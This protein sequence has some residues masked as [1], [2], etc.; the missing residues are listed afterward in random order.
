MSFIG[1]L[2]REFGY[3]SALLKTQKILADLTPDNTGLMADDWEATCAKHSSKT[4]IIFE[5]TRWTYGE[6][7]GRANRYAHWALAQGLKA[8][9][10]VA[11]YMGNRP[12]YLAAWYGLI[13][14]G[15]VVALINNNL[16]GGPL[17]HCVNIAKSKAVI[18]D[19]EQVAGW[20]T[21]AASIPDVSVWVLGGAA[22]VGSD[23]SEALDGQPVSRPA[24][25]HR[26]MLRGK[27][28]CLYVYTSGTT[29]NPKAATLTQIRTQGMSRAF[30]VG[31]RVNE[32]DVVY[33]P[34]P[35]YHG[36][37]GICGVG[38]AFNTGATLVI[39]RKF[40][41]SQFWD[42]VVDNG[43]T[44]FAYIGEL[45]RYLVAQPVHP[46]ERAHRLK[47]CFGN[48]LRPDVWAKA[49]ERF[50]IPR[51]VEFY[52]STEGNVSFI[53]FDGKRGA[54]GRI[55]PYM[56]KKFNVEIVKFDIEEE[57]PVRGPDGFCIKADFGEPGEAIG[58]I[59]VDDSRGRFEGYANDTAA[60]EKKI[61]RDVFEKGDVW[62]RT[63][64]LIKT[65]EEG[66][67]YFVDRIGD[68][69][70]WKSEN[71]STNEVG[72]VLA[73]FEGIQL[74]NVYGVEVPHNDGRA[75]M[76]AIVVPG[77]A[78]SIDFARL[79]AHLKAQLPAYAIPL[80]LRIQPEAEVTG[81]FKYRK[82]DAVKQGYDPA[83]CGEPV[84]WLDPAAG[85]YV[86]V[87]AAAMSRMNEGSVKF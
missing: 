55:A 87:D 80:F 83:A 71:V 13:K 2:T 78:G 64:D 5:G 3:V 36:T 46:K 20:K 24:R 47:S 66:Y 28:P 35:L 51:I 60:T 56:K 39:R 86:P 31:T 82:V 59:T 45:F 34:L 61:L 10:V 41:A 11:L 57:K 79:L 7:D 23:L 84:Y 43:V 62:F 15:I 54:V 68:T 4:A 42:D 9:D 6:F 21:A 72:E 76:G 25:S 65:D 50:A 17:A 27:D 69:Y 40:S 14:V 18:M 85:G 8:G 32:N 26:E 52:G 75:G 33:V 53:N 1:T 30:I 19:G 63:G 49:D 58:K 38:L 16:S 70:R 73:M 81:T 48:G 29:G 77:G 74:A 67:Y 22:D 37:G 12:D 44:V